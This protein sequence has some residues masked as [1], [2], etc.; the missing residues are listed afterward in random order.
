MLSQKEINAI[1][2]LLAR[3]SLRGD[4]VVVFNMVTAALDR[5]QVEL[6]AQKQTGKEGITDGT[7]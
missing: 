5:E 4:E 2:M 6:L 1:K 3:T 7:T